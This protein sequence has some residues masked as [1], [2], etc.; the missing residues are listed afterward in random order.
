MKRIYWLSIFLVAALTLSA[1]T[2]QEI[3]IFE[4]GLKV[5]GSSSQIAQYTGDDGYNAFGTNCV[6]TTTNSGSSTQTLTAVIPADV[7]SLGVTCRVD[8]VLAGSGLTTWSLGDGT[9]ADLYGGSLA[10]TAGTIVDQTTYTANPLTQAWS[11]NAGNLTMT[12]AA[13]VFSSGAVTCCSHYVKF[14]APTS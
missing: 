5:T 13:G 9:D 14:I 4:Q 8:T 12:A 11:T 7:R 6:T 3:M 2:Y 10:K 1:A